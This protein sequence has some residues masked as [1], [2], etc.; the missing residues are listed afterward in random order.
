MTNAVTSGGQ[1]PR[2]ARRAIM[3]LTLI[4]WSLLLGVGVAFL[5]QYAATG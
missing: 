2:R 4:A 5:V 3:W 1:K